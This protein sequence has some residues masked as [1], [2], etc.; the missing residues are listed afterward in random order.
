MSSF[1]FPPASCFIPA[2][3][4]LPSGDEMLLDNESGN[5][6]PVA[7]SMDS[8]GSS[9]LDL[10][11]SAAVRAVPFFGGYGGADPAPPEDL[12]DAMVDDGDAVEEPVDANKRRS[13]GVAGRGGRPVG[14]GLRTRENFARGALRVLS[15]ALQQLG[16]ATMLDD[17]ILGEVPAAARNR[18]VALLQELRDVA[19]KEE[20]LAIPYLFGVT[21]RFSVW[22]TTD[23]GKRSSCS[24]WITADGFI[25][26]TCVG[27]DTYNSDCSVHRTSTCE[28]IAVFSVVIE[29]MSK[30]LDISGAL[31]MKWLHSCMG[32]KPTTTTDVLTDDEPSVWRFH[33]D[34]VVVVCAERGALI[35]VPVYLPRKGVSCGFCPLAN[36]GGCSHTRVAEQYRSSAGAAAMPV[37]AAN[38]VRSAVSSK[39]ISLFNCPDSV[40]FDRRVGDLARRG[41][42]FVL[43]PPDVCTA[44]GVQMVNPPRV[45]DKP[46][47]GILHSTLGPCKMSVVRRTCDGCGEVCSRDGRENK[48]VLL[49]WTSGCTALWGRRCAELV[50]SGTH[51]SDVINFNTTEWSGLRSAGLLPKSVKSRAADTLRALILTT[52]RL[53]VVDPD[54]GLYDCK[55]CQLPCGRYLVITAD[56]ICLGYDSGS[57]PFSFEHVCESA[58]FVNMKT[59]EGCMVLGEQARRMMRHVLIP[60]D[61]A[62]VSD[63]T[64]P[65]SEMALSCLF[66]AAFGSAASKMDSSTTAASIR[67]LLG[68]VWNIEAAAIPLAESLLAAYKSTKVK[69][70]KEKQRRSEMAAELEVSIKRWR[71]DNPDAV[72]MQAWTAA[73]DDELDGNGADKDPSALAVGA[74]VGGGGGTGRRRPKGGHKKAAKAK[75]KVKPGEEPALGISKPLLQPVMRTLDPNDVD[76]ICRMALAFAL[77]PVIAGIKMRHFAG[78]RAIYQALRAEQPRAVIEGMVAEATG[79]SRG[80]FPMTRAAHCLVE[81]R[82]IKVALQAAVLVFDRCAELALAIADVLQHAVECA[83]RFYA[84]FSEELQSRHEYLRRYLKP[85]VTDAELIAAFQE[86]YPTASSKT[87]STGIYTPGRPQCRAEAYD[88]SDK[89]P[90]GTCEKGFASSDKFS[91]GALT[92]CCACAHPKILGFVVLDRK[93]SP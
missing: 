44:C 18:F 86:R 13:G 3:A 25:R 61:P 63:R 9:L 39:P 70:L 40:T 77:D 57:T 79:L 80:R 32:H 15:E 81:L 41:S 48:L 26:C 33:K 91:D 38:Y 87:A 31:V 16:T 92:L 14:T 43:E 52:M 60:N 34:I 6:S 29:R 83:G 11:A 78:L 21:A 90:C 17:P 54:A 36:L 66:P 76:H 23:H 68:L 74:A 42:V 7:V 45:P 85:G 19:G 89:T 62:A 37:S 22:G 50:R 93:E 73:S 64:L 27:S 28:H 71:K 46:L 88:Q 75:A 51:I 53:C 69:R 30:A 55:I 5:S 10:Y 12:D 8:S 1:Y 4:S 58:P 72:A 35:P 65:S 24:T 49:S 59:R 20:I 47:P 2:S 84:D 82:H 56:G 67:R